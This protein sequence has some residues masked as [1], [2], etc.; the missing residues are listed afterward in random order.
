MSMDLPRIKYD[1]TGDDAKKPKPKKV[2][3]D[4]VDRLNRKALAKMQA[5]AAEAEKQKVS[6]TSIINR[7]QWQTI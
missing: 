1:K 2:D 5:Q 4:E 7:E 3:I 6:L